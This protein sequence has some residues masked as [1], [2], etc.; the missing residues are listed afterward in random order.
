MSEQSC[1]CDEATLR[2]LRGR[3]A[4]HAGQ[5]MQSARSRERSLTGSELTDNFWHQ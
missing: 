4:T 3:A 2:M 5:R 1:G